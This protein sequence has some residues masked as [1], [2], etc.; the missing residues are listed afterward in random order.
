MPFFLF[1]KHLTHGH[2]H[3]LSTPMMQ[4]AQAKLPKLIGTA[5]VMGF[6]ALDPSYEERASARGFRRTAE[7]DI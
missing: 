4:R 5:A 3:R 1:R 6:A 2:F 7:A